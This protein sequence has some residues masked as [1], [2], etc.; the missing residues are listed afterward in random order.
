MKPKK[1]KKSIAIPAP[2]WAS[3]TEGADEQGMSYS[4]YICHILMKSVERKKA[5]I[6]KV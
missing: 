3:L 4:A 5:R 2:L 1:L 6:K